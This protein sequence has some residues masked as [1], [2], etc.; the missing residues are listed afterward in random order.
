MTVGSLA[1]SALALIDLMLV[2]IKMRAST[3]VQLLN[4]NLHYIN[5]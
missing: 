1:L 5:Q 2:H 3:F 4:V